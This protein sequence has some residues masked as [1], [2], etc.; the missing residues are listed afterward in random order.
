MTSHGFDTARVA[1]GAAG[2]AAIVVVLALGARSVRRRW[3]RRTSGV[4]AALADSI[5]ATSALVLVAELLGTLHQLKPVPLV[6]GCIVAGGLCW[7]LGQGGSADARPPAPVL[8]ADGEW[9]RGAGMVA[10]A[11]VAITAGQWI[12]RIVGVLR[13]GI[14]S[15]DSVAYHLPFAARFAQTGRTTGIYFARPEFP[16][17]FH[18]AGAE[19][20]HAIGMVMLRTDLLSVFL[21]LGFVAMALAGAWVIGERWGNGPLAVVATCLLLATPVMGVHHA[22]TASND[23][24]AL[25]FLLA[26]GAFVAPRHGEIAPAVVA[27]LAAGL[28]L[29]TK[30]TAAIPAAVLVI[31]IAFVTSKQQRAR[32]FLGALAAA[33][34]TGSYWM[35]RNFVA[36]GSPVPAVNLPLLPRYHYSIVEAQGYTV[37]HY[38]SKPGIVR[39]FYVPG[40]RVDFGPV[41]WFSI[42]VIGA[43]LVVALVQGDRRARILTAAAAAGGAYYL[44]MPTGAMGPLN[45]PRLFGSNVRY[46]IPAL[47][48]GIVAIAGAAASRRLVGRVAL[49]VLTVAFV[50]S[51][52]ARAPLPAWPASGRVFGVVAAALV[53]IAFAVVQRQASLSLG[54]PVAF[55][56][57]VLVVLLAIAGIA[58]V[59]NR[60]ER[61]RYRREPI[62]AWA[63][64]LHHVRIGVSGV[65]GQYFEYGADLTNHIEY[66]GKR[67]GRGEFRAP[68]NCTDW[69]RIIRARRFDYL[70]VVS[71]DPFVK[72]VHAVEWLQHDPAAK[73]LPV[74]GH[75]SVYRLDGRVPD[76]G[77]GS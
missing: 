65:G 10:V 51:Q 32:A 38:L 58:G 18:H 17:A 24:V 67:V 75:D 25:A 44:V 34:V 3:L 33:A 42:A 19:L 35:V 48:I 22:G 46:V 2:L 56:A 13:H 66:V 69:R 27:G 57:A 16:D 41:W 52:L 23:V 61:N 37:A 6:V 53:V 72:S 71:P 50:A 26:A 1:L 64:R 68:V 60:F 29:G 74:R 5:I 8:P 59:G 20:L 54:R 73:R 40:L 43:A 39:R 7:V 36:T 70:V 21:N 55:G 9:R 12:D 31:G 62:A 76:P 77:C 47:A 4:E 11:T 28:A 15:H 14:T 63:N 49:V 45:H 30:L